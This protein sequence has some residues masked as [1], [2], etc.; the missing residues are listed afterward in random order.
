[1]NNKYKLNNFKEA[2]SKTNDKTINHAI[3][4]ITMIY[5]YTKTPKTIINH[6]GLEPGIIPYINTTLPP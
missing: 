5:K 1:M 4:I 6:L 3:Y 2:S